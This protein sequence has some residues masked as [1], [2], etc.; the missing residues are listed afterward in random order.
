MDAKEWG[1][2][3][4]AKECGLRNRKRAFRYYYREI[5]FFYN[6]DYVYMRNLKRTFRYIKYL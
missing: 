3:G 2:L 1:F 5:L 4:H 6:K